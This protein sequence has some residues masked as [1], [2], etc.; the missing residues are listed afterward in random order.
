MT[1]V[2]PRLQGLFRIRVLFAALVISM[3]LSMVSSIIS[4]L[5]GE[6]S[7]SECARGSAKPQ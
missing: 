7:T 3:R 5:V 4:A 6:S 1:L 2:R